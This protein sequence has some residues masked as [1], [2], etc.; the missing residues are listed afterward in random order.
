[1]DYIITEK[2]KKIK[3]SY[4]RSRIKDQTSKLVIP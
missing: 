3:L 2:E 1:M 4:L